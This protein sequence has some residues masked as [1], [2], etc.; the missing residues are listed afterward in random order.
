MSQNIRLF[1]INK[2]DNIII[3]SNQNRFRKFELSYT[4]W[5]CV[6]SKNCTQLPH[7]QSIKL[8]LYTPSKKALIIE[9]C[10]RDHFPFNNIKIINIKMN[11]NTKMAIRASQYSFFLVKVFEM[12]ANEILHRTNFHNSVQMDNSLLRYHEGYLRRKNYLRIKK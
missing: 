10:I 9:K 2:S 12:L 6:F 11:L 3:L 4:Q 5:C 7:K 1:D 8:K